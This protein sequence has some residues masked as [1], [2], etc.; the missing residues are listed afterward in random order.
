VARARSQAVQTSELSRARW[1]RPAVRT[2]LR[3]FTAFSE[4]RPPELVI[5]A[6]NKYFDETSDSIVEH[7]GTLVAYRGDGF[8]AVF[9]APIEFDDHADRALATA[10]DIV[11]VR[12]PRFNEWLRGEGVGEEIRL[13]VGLNR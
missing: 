3:G 8:L 2:D 5:D 7:G 12:L 6:L 9:G 13:G 11:D 10:R 4:V 1:P